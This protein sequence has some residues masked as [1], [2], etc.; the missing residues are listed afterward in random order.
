MLLATL[1]FPKP[2]QTGYFG[3]F[4]QFSTILATIEAILWI[5][6]LRFWRFEIFAVN[7]QIKLVPNKKLRFIKLENN[8]NRDKKS[9]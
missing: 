1:E 2:P 4:Y 9:L 6:F 8:Q 3:H 5:T 7:C